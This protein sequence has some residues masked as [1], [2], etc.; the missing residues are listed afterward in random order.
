[1]YKVIQASNK[2]GEKIAQ[3]NF[4]SAPGAYEPTDATNALIDQIGA[5][6]HWEPMILADMTVEE[7]MRNLGIVQIR[8][9]T[10]YND[11]RFKAPQTVLHEIKPDEII[12]HG[13]VMIRDGKRVGLKQLQDLLMTFDD[14]L[15]TYAPSDETG[16]F[17]NLSTIEHAE[18]GIAD[19][20]PPDECYRALYENTVSLWC[21]ILNEINE[22]AGRQVTN[23]GPDPY[24]GGQFKET[25]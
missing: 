6:E 20:T 21:R 1:M 14:F 22:V 5:N 9:L 3:I 7:C 17:D 11:G 12:D 15:L 8:V 13:P 24:D 19:G 23:A 16:Q 18:A 25:N 2:F 4:E 10:Y